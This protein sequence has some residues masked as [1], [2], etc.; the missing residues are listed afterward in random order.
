MTDIF[1][2][3][4]YSYPILI[5]EVMFYEIILFSIA[6]TFERKRSLIRSQEVQQIHHGSV[7]RL[8][9]LCILIAL[10]VGFLSYPFLIEREFI[11]GLFFCFIPILVITI[12]EDF[13]INL[14][15]QYRI[16]AMLIA[17]FLLL[18]TT[19]NSL[20]EIS[21]PIMGSMLNL[22]YILPIFYVI[23]IIALINGMNFIDGANGLLAMSLL[24]IFFGLGLTAYF[25][26]D[27]NLLLII[28]FFSFPLFIFLS[29]NYPW[30]KIF[31]GDVGAY[32]FGWV[33]GTLA[34]YLYSKHEELLTWSVPLLLFYPTMEVVFSFFRKVFQKKSPFNP[35]AYHLHLK[36]YFMLN[37]YFK[38]HPQRANNLV[39]PLLTF[40]WFTPPILSA[41]FYQNLLMTLLALIFFIVLYLSLYWFIPSA[42]SD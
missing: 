33:V 41:L 11:N 8:A 15:P 4:I 35:D 31:M 37:H 5:I 13:H 34:I 40:F 10:F 6:I 30:G 1:L 21:L 18:F 36:I 9:G 27:F 26:N 29:F 2:Q 16:F 28:L 17:S 20:P 25:V 32:W 19:I 12:F 22:P 23:A 38:H 3:F 14:K 42:P 24:C 39:M 7:S